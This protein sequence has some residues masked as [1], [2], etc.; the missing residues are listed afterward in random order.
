MHPVYRS[1]AQVLTL[2]ETSSASLRTFLYRERTRLGTEWPRVYALAT[3]THRWSHEL[4]RIL[5]S[6]I[7]QQP[8]DER[9][10]WHDWLRRPTNHWLARVVVY[11]RCFGRGNL[12][13]AGG[14]IARKLKKLLSAST[15]SCGGSRTNTE[16]PPSFQ[17]TEDNRFFWFR[18]QVLGGLDPA[19]VERAFPG[20]VE[21]DL[22]YPDLFW[23]FHGDL[24][25]FLSHEWV[26]RGLLIVQDRGS[27]LAALALQPQRGWHLIDACAAPGNKSMF[28][29]NLLQQ[30]GMVYA[31]ERDAERYRAMV[32]RVRSAG[33]TQSIRMHL[34]DFRTVVSDDAHDGALAQASAI[35][36]DPSCSGS[37]LVRYRPVGERYNWS[38]IGRL[39]AVQIQLLRHALVAFPRVRRVVYSTCS[40][41]IEENE[42]VVE[43]LLADPFIASRWRLDTVFPAWP[44]RGLA[45]CSA[46]VRIPAQAAQTRTPLGVS[47]PR[48]GASTAEIATA[49]VTGFSSRSAYFIAAFERRDA[50]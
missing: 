3:E 48:I 37:G 17:Q 28:L 34:K 45:G 7:Q 15:T 12:L 20:C 24:G 30:S 32:S 4:E 41:L 25:A 22:A 27:C 49:P 40:V 50:Q 5:Q 33:F 6:A 13:R 42:K 35:L 8:K 10:W 2:T 47:G 11:E 14:F 23:C 21:R 19:A 16:E 36:V 26:Q 44:H 9:R 39:A 29:A 18:P 38:R 31:F 46:A 43:A 1:V